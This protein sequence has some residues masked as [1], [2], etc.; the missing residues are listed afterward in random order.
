MDEFKRALESGT[1]LFVVIL[2]APLAAL[3][4]AVL[5]VYLYMIFFPTT[6]GET[7]ELRD[8]FAMVY[9]VVYLTIC[10]FAVKGA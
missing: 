8:I 1:V 9:A 7:G 6:L 5:L 2:S 4:I 3:L 10:F